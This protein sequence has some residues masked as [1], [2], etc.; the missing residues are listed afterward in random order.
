MKQIY[1]LTLCALVGL[2]ACNTPKK[3][4]K[5]IVLGDTIQ[6]VSGLKYYYEKI[7][8]GRKVEPGCDLGTYLSLKVNDKV[9]W[10][11]AE[12]PDSLFTYVAGY[13]RVIK[14]FAEVSLLLREGDEIVAIL[15]DSIAYGAKGAGDIIPP[16]STLIY[17]KFKMLKVGEPKGIMVDTLLKAIETGGEQAVMAKYTQITTTADSNKYHIGQDH[18][19]RIWDKLSKANEHKKAAE[20][21]ACFADVT[22]DNKLWYKMVLSLESLGEIKE[23]KENLDILIGK[24]PENKEMTA[25]MIDLKEKL[26]KR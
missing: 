22:K 5:K 17:D 21:A 19:Y 14:G 20:V 12:M 24:D 25:K 1:L 8:Q 23:A 10:T 13:S 11:S 7:G 3:S 2:S 16:Y 26:S 4:E 18:L 9:I 15:P 6:T